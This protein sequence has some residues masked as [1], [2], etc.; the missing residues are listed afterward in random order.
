LFSNHL[1]SHI[2]Q[3]GLKLYLKKSDICFRGH[4]KL[5]NGD[6]GDILII[7]NGSDNEEKIFRK[8]DGSEID[9]VLSLGI[10]Y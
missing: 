5:K 10:E 7:S 2:K 6:P 8:G 1:C 9:P 3:L 4:R